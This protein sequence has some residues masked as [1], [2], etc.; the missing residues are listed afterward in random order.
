MVLKMSHP[1]VGNVSVQW[2]SDDLGYARNSCNK[3]QFMTFRAVN[4]KLKRES[5]FC[6]LRIEIVCIHF[7]KCDFRDSAKDNFRFIA[8]PLFEHSFRQMRK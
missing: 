4:V 5:I 3:R 1:P 7:E 8:L 6:S 2:Q